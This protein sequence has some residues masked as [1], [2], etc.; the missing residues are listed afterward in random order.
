MP[1]ERVKNP[2]DVAIV[3]FPGSN[4]DF[5]TLR[6][7]Q[8]RGHNPQFLWHEE[9][10]TPKADLL[11]LPGGFANG[12]RVFNRATESYSID[13]GVQALKAPVMKTVYRWAKAEL[14]ILGICNGFQILVHA[15]LLPGALLRNEQEKFFCDDV[16]V[17]VEGKSFFGAQFMTGNVYRINVAHGFGRYSGDGHEN[18][19]LRY[20]GFN[21][22]GSFED[23]A[24]ICNEDGNIF[25]M[26]PHP[27]RA[28]PAT[29]ILFLEAIEKYVR[30]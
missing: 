20:Y 3:R 13:P 21:P 8:R 29:R 14:P 23:V 19:F 5:D 4:C 30:D 16:D 6:F 18:V 1:Q 28:D 2:L 7:F 9:S 27:E 11:V 17:R 25:G 10:E 24:G 12:D 22:N 15:G 26:M